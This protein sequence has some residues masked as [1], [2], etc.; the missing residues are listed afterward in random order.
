[1]ALIKCNNCGKMVS[2][3][4]MVCPHCGCDPR[5]AKETKAED[6]N[7]ANP[8]L[9][10]CPHCGATISKKA[11]VCP[12]CGKAIQ[13]PP[14]IPPVNQPDTDGTED[15]QY[16]DEDENTSNS[17]LRVI[18]IVLALIALIFAAVLISGKRY[19]TGKT[20]KYDINNVDSD[21]VS[22]DTTAMDT[23]AVDSAYSDYP[24]YADSIP[25]GYDNEPVEEE[26]E[27]FRNNTDVMDFVVG[28]SYSHNG[29]T[30]R[31][32][33][34][35]V[36]ADDNKISTSRPVFRKISNETG[37]ITAHPSISITVRR[38]ENKLIDNNNG[39]EYYY[40][41]DNYKGKHL[42][43]QELNLDDF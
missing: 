34:S 12:K 20:L 16:I 43:S 24:Y 35:G 22:V 21:S 5:K 29:I 9:T 27:G 13:T 10:S 40:G 33:E 2:D 25:G 37:R 41:T 14:P 1:M 17:G 19:Y 3:R 7:T 6:V 42:S 28:N 18:V 8:N 4:A 32:S 26:Q 31:I 36:Y 23:S 39:D 38:S 30:L 11:K 15:Y